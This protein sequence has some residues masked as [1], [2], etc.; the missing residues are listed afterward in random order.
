MP[1][2]QAMPIA[3]EQLLDHLAV[4]ER[5]IARGERIIRKQRALVQRLDSAGLSTVEA[6]RLLHI[7]ED[8]QRSHRAD[9]DRVMEQLQRRS[10]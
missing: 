8:M 9:R 3:R 4:A 5:H 10:P 1:Y 2:G 7:F 6:Q